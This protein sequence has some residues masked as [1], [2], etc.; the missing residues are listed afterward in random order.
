MYKILIIIFLVLLGTLGLFY[1]KPKE[2]ILKIHTDKKIRITPV[3]KEKKEK[4]IPII[5]KKSAKKT[6]TKESPSSTKMQKETPSQMPLYKSLTIEEAKLSTPPRKKVAPIGAIQIKQRMSELQPNDTLT[7]SDVEGL[8]YT[9]TV[10]STLTNNDGS[11]STTANYEDEGITYTTTITQ[12]DK[13]TYITLSTANGL[14]EIE[15]NADTGYIYKTIDIRKQLQ[16]R[17]PNDVIIL[18]IPKE[19]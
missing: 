8:D 18:P 19:K 9:L 7:L 12:S 5:H 6:V 11:T 1:S 14:Y 15:T 13:S 10:Q 3:I 4:T 17:T 16:S 2:E